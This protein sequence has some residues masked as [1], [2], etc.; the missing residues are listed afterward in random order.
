MASPENAILNYFFIPLQALGADIVPSGSPWVSVSPW[1]VARYDKFYSTCTSDRQ[2]TLVKS[3]LSN[4]ITMHP[5]KPSTGSSSSYFAQTSA[6]VIENHASL[7]APPEGL[8]EWRD[9]E[10]DRDLSMFTHT[11]YSFP[12]ADNSAYH[13]RRTLRIDQT[14]GIQDYSPQFEAAFNELQNTGG[15]TVLVGP[16]VFTHS[17]QI[18][19]PSY[20]CLQGAGMDRTVLRVADYSPPFRNSGAIRTR[21]SERVSLLDF[22]QDGNRARQNLRNDSERYGRYGIYSHLS[23][24]VWMRGVRVRGNLRYAFDPHGSNDRWGYFLVIEDCISEG[25]GLDGYTIHQYFYAS[26]LRCVGRNNDRHGVNVIS[27]SRFMLVK[28]CL[29]EIN[30][31]R[32]GK[33]FG[34]CAQNNATDGKLDTNNLIFKENRVKDCFRGAVCLRDVWNVSV[35]RNLFENCSSTREYVVYELNETRE[36]AIRLNAIVGE[37][38]RKLKI[39]NN[40]QFDESDS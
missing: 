28:G 26:V 12:P 24:F 31:V 11:D 39:L 14:A 5:F 2:P 38:R 9:L 6:E 18:A 32:S 29:F 40:A 3:C 4:L 13:A 20:C 21:H 30:G 35:E 36:V 23:N 19:V 33:G 10:D 7:P 22:T 27:G 25:N 37:S 17:R 15:G 34:I 16:G 1:A 8:G